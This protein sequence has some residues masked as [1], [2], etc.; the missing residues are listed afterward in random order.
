MCNLHESAATLSLKGAA[1]VSLLTVDTE[2]APYN[3]KKLR[4]KD[5]G[6]S[7][8]MEEDTPHTVRQHTVRGVCDACRWCLPEPCAL[9]QGQIWGLLSAP[10]F[11]PYPCRPSA[12]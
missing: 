10:S 9:C 6:P 5:G 2:A 11:W 12:C 3:G 7:K 8:V 4:L 1:S